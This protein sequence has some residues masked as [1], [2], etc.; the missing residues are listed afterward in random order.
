[1]TEEGNTE[2]EFGGSRCCPSS[3]PSGSSLSLSFFLVDFL[4]LFLFI[5]LHKCSVVWCGVVICVQCI[6]ILWLNSITQMIDDG[7]LNINYLPTWYILSNLIDLTSSFSQW[8]NPSLSKLVG[9]LSSILKLKKVII[10]TEM[11]PVTLWY[12]L[13]LNSLYLLWRMLGIPYVRKI[14]PLEIVK[15]VDL[16]SFSSLQVPTVQELHFLESF[17]EV[18]NPTL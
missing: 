13:E 1:M 8:F 17:K 14:L 11:I 5:M 12:M 9:L 7:Q 3:S 16:I 15:L 6:Q 4:Y 2:S 18:Q 10:L